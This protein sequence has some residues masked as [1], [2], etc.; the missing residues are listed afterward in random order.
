LRYSYEDKQVNFSQI[1]ATGIYT[2]FG[3]PNLTYANHVSNGDLSPT[4]SLSWQAT[5]DIMAYARISRGYKSAAFNVDLVSSTFGLSA[6]PENATS[7]EIGLKTDWLDHRLRADGALFITKYND[8]QVSELPGVAPVLTNAADSTVKGAELELTAILAQGLRLQTGIGA[9]DLHYDSFPYCPVPVSAGGGSINCAGKQIVGAADW[10]GNAALEYAQSLDWGG[11]FIARVEYVFESPVYFE[12]T[13]S[14]R[15]ES[16]SH[17]LINARAGV[18]FGAYGVAMWVKNLGNDT[19]ITYRDDRSTI[20]I[21]QTTAYG[22]PRTF[23]AT[24]S[25]HF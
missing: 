16:D 17:G 1:D 3:L 10:T 12:A 4:A 2:F 14:K 6:R 11:D 19:Y 24:L 7:Y 23:G 8:M 15:F 25:A 9:L 22:A 5:S 13:N 20:G 21:L 18:D